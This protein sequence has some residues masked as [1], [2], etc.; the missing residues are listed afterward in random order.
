FLIGQLSFNDFT[1]GENFYQ[2]CIYFGRYLFVFFV[3][4]FLMNKEEKF[5]SR[6]FWV[7]EKLVILNSLLVLIAILFD[8]QLFKTYY[9]RFGS[10]GIFMTPSMIT[11]FNALGLTY[12]LY[13]YLQ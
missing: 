3:F 12:F 13:Q 10:S 4:F 6:L 2:N 5:S 7:F 8:I 9:H 1:P 11:Y